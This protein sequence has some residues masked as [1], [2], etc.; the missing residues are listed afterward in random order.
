MKKIWPALFLLTILSG[1]FE[2]SAG[3]ET[4]TQAAHEANFLQPTDRAKLANMEL[5]TC[6]NC[7]VI[8]VRGGRNGDLVAY[9]LGS[10]QPLQILLPMSDPLSPLHHLV[11]RRKAAGLET[12]LEVPVTVSKRLLEENARGTTQYF[13]YP[14]NDL[15]SQCFAGGDSF[16]HN[17]EIY[18]YQGQ[19][20]EVIYRHQSDREGVFPLATDGKRMFFTLDTAAE[21]WSERNRK[22]VEWDWQSSQLVPVANAEVQSPAEILGFAG[23]IVNDTLY[24]D[25]FDTKTQLWSLYQLDLNSPGSPAKLLATDLADISGLYSLG[26]KL[27]VSDGKTI[28][29]WGGSDSFPYQFVSYFDGPTQTLLQELNDASLVVTDTST[30]KV[31]AEFPSSE[32]GPAI[33]YRIEDDQLVI[34]FD[35]EI[36]RVSLD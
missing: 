18:C 10:K 30:K 28:T 24:Y 8:G 13:T 5:P 34:Y 9:D 1:C 33:D 25:G 36:K 19:E 7:I 17:F 31:I 27:Y 15:R 23:A 4:G 2:P 3:K 21:S 20:V 6:P 35:G 29:E 22:I 16:A 11:E 32:Y 26:D 14:F 12:D